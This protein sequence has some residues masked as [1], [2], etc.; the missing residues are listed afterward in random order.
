LVVRTEPAL[1]D[2][3]TLAQIRAALHAGR[4]TG[5]VTL[6]LSVAHPE[7]RDKA[8][9]DKFFDYVRAY[10]VKVERHR[11]QTATAVYLRTRPS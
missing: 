7:L 6:E 9:A 2:W 10:G 4:I 3:H 8:A 11:L 1:S 5:G